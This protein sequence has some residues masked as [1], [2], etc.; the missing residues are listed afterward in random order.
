LLAQC[1]LVT[2]SGPAGVGKTRLA[3]AVAS[4]VADWLADGA[5]LVELAGAS[6]PL[7]VPATIATALGVPETATDGPLEAL[8][9]VLAHREML[10]VL[11]NCEHVI[12]V[13]AGLVTSLLTR[14]ARTR[15]LAT[16]RE[17]LRVPG[18]AVFRLDPLPIPDIAAAGTGDAL[19]LFIARAT[20][21]DHRFTLADRDA[22][23]AI[24][25]V[26]R[27]DGLPLAIELVA[28][29]ATV[30]SIVELLER[31]DSHPELLVNRGRGA[32]SRHRSLQAAIEWSDA[33]LTRQQRTVFYRLSVF[34]G[35]CT[36]G[37]AER[38]CAAPGD[39]TGAE[40]ADAMAA[41]VDKSVV[42]ARPS[43]LGTR[44]VLLDTVRRYAAARLGTG[45]GNEP[46]QAAHL[47]WLLDLASEA[48]VGLDSPD[49]SIW[50][51]RLEAE[52]DNAGAGLRWAVEQDPPAALTLA[53]RLSCWWRTV[54]RLAEGRRWLEAALA[55]NSAGSPAGIAAALL[56]LGQIIQDQLDVVG[57]F[58]V[59]RQ[60][61]S[62][63]ETSGDNE[64]ITRATIGMAQTLRDSGDYEAATSFAT[65][66]LSLARDRGDSRG[67]ARALAALAFLNVYSGEFDQARDFG[68]R[69][70]QLLN[71]DD[72]SDGAW[73]ATAAAAIANCLAGAL[74]ASEVRATRALAL[75]EQLG[76]PFEIAWTHST[77]GA[78]AGIRRDAASE[79]EHGRQCLELSVDIG[80]KR[81]LTNALMCLAHAS[82]L[83][84]NYKLGATLAGATSAIVRREGFALPP[85]FHRYLRLDSY[86]DSFQ[87]DPQPLE[88]TYRRGQ[89]LPAP[90][91]LELARSVIVPGRELAGATIAA[92]P[93]SPR[94]RE[95]VSLVANGL[96]DAQIAD[97][98]SI[99]IRT[100]RSHLDRIRDKT[101][102]RRRADLTRL[103]SSLDAEAGLID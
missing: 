6:D 21:A 95:L 77:L 19:A 71:N 20:E 30:F 32:P 42:V 53:T 83:T 102:A 76:S 46:Q 4:D 44:Y 75:A 9:T 84:G 57:S 16:S 18:E 47:A 35:G 72:A 52:V 70:V 96:T 61:L 25:L 15:I 60:A 88:A 37:T 48:S 27:L 36:L 14:T 24:E 22:L 41:L 3:A 45:A 66:A 29:N 11:D 5:S 38:V 93:L 73:E 12:D 55:A 85:G 23:A 13:A 17:P 90:E 34:A 54:G 8:V 31:L 7:A 99:S 74:N 100:V 78:I 65:R 26:R 69:A 94:E 97:Q 103:A 2:V 58:T 64:L 49:R 89:T 51:S 101:G 63:A 82:G 1:R 86:A 98:L 56:E 33:L 28:A 79:I 81:T 39:L 92:Y 80:S 91:I 67:Q 50:K 59:H 68:E 62:A 40:V 10:I 87:T 43:A